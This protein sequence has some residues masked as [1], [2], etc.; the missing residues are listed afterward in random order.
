MIFFII[1]I[2]C[3]ICLVSIFLAYR[4][5][6][7]LGIIPDRIWIFLIFLCF[8]P[9]LNTVMLLMIMFNHDSPQVE[10]VNE[11]LKTMEELDKKLREL[12]DKFNKR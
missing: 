4:S 10:D 9:I 11:A 2:F 5:Q 6:D 1:Y 3:V 7:T 8:I 12:S